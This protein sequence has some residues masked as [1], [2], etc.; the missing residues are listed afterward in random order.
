[1]FSLVRATFYNIKSKNLSLLVFHR[2]DLQDK[3]ISMV[4]NHTS[5]LD[6]CD[7]AN[8]TEADLRAA[9]AELIALKA[10]GAR[11]RRAA[12]AARARCEALTTAASASA[13]EATRLRGELAQL[14]AVC[15]ANLEEEARL[16]RELS[17]LAAADGG[18][19]LARAQ[20]E[21]AEAQ[22]HHAEVKSECQRAEG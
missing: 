12:T 3:M 7:N 4:Q 9:T 19:E 10:E 8:S 20:K 17:R 5:F 18:G 14:E 15:R 21:V 2:L 16:T 6:L 22:R 13:A 11:R 1:M